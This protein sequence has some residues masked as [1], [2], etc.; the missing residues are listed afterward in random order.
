M[1]SNYEWEDLSDSEV[2][3]RLIHRGVEMELAYYYV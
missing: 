2:R 3:M 1:D